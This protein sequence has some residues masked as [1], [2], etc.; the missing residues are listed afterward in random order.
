MKARSS[1][2]SES[3][4]PENDRVPMSHSVQLNAPVPA[5]L[6]DEFLKKLAY[7]SEALTSY[8]LNPHTR[9]AVAFE[10]RHGS[11]DSELIASRIVEVADK[12][13]K[14]RRPYTPRIL[15]SNRAR[16]F[17]FRSDPHSALEQMGELQKYGEGRFGLGP[18][19]LE[20]MELFDRDVQSMA[21]HVA[22]MPYRFPTLIGADLLD[23]CR[24]LR[25]FPST[26][27]MVSHLR[28]DLP[29]I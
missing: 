15:H 2:S 3:C 6:A 14:G 17:Q 1:A 26:L 9:A 16:E 11:A 27:T 12:L 22:A 10:L 24:Y 8:R 7:V 4:R 25:S 28:E 21:E 23:R 20:L 5:E 18:R 13:C 19:V 29:A